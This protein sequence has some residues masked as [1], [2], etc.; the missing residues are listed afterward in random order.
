MKKF[1]LPVMALVTLNVPVGLNVL[2]ETGVHELT[3]RATL[4][5]LTVC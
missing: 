1:R 5:E 3:G 2:V 4:V